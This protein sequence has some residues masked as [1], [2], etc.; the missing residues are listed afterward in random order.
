ME[1]ETINLQTGTGGVT[2][3]KRPRADAE[4]KNATS[5]HEGPAGHHQQRQEENRG[6]RERSV[7]EHNTKDDPGEVIIKYNYPAKVPE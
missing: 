6:G 1:K 4:W 5:I 3:K 2:W 7:R